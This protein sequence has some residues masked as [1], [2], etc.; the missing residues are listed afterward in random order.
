MSDDQP[1]A[2]KK[3]RLE[4]GE[5]DEEGDREPER[6]EADTPAESSSSSAQAETEQTYHKRITQLL[7][8]MARD[9]IINILATM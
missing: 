5:N 2:G 1:V 7:R 4:E 3:R 8:F 9:T 6:Q